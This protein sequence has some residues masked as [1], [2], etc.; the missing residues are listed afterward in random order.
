MELTE[1][2]RNVLA[3]DS[4]SADPADLE[5]FKT[6]NPLLADGESPSHVVR[7]KNVSELQK[8]V[9]LANENRLACVPVSSGGNHFRGGITCDQEHIVIDLSAW[10]KIPWVQRKNRVCIVEPGVTYGELL[11]VLAAEGMTI[12]T[13][14]APRA[15]KSVLAAVMD[16][17][18]CIWPGV[19]WEI[20]DPV[21]ATELLFGTGDL[22][23]TGAAGAK[24]TLEEQHRRGNTSKGPLGPSA[25]DFQKIVQGSQGTMGI[26]TWVSLRCQ[27]E[28]SIQ[29]PYLV[30]SDDLGAL[31]SYV[32]PV[33]RN[34]WGE[35]SFILNRTAVAMLMTHQDSASFDEVKNALSEFV[36][37]QNIAGFEILPEERVIYQ[38][39]GIKKIAADVGLSLE[40]KIGPVSARNML[41]TATHPCGE[42]DWR[43][44]PQGNCLSV[45]IMTTLDRT[46]DFIKVF[47][48]CAS[49][50]KVGKEEIGIHI[51]PLVQNHLVHVE[52]MVPYDPR[53]AAE[54]Q[55]MR[56][57]ESEAFRAL[58]DAHAF[59]NR[60][61]GTAWK[62]VFK[63]NP[64]NTRLLKT[65]K[66]IFD[67]NRV[68]NPGKFGI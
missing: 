5:A 45:I 66:G 9:K 10:K 56:T 60:P 63:N 68:L 22:F 52:F 39:E 20:Q 49:D 43:H 12:P 23:R 36:C 19:Q 29:K 61:Y 35:H 30:A 67:P 41:K 14:L 11:P 33:Q 18:A 17:E 54:I 15:G 6:A 59:F 40:P 16:R 65:V 50:N 21:G 53:D 4:I 51:Q 55:K 7:P 37:L 58:N 8:L 25:T 38:E 27:I 46:P 62:M 48:R 34:V 1:V 57:L 32:Y 13:P 44:T 42:K 24:G 26:A 64:T 47:T 3:G 2:L 31:I 28:P